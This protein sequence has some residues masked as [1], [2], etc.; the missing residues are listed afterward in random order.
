V[1]NAGVILSRGLKCVPLIA[2][3]RLSGM[4]LLLVFVFVGKQVMSEPV[5]FIYN[6][7]K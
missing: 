7:V 5:K 4:L 3:E 1:L 2:F 6:P